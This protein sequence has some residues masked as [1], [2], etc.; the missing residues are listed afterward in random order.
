MVD[1]F[2][3]RHPEY[4]RDGVEQ[5]QQGATN[6]VIFA[7][8][9]DE[10]VV[11]K[12]FC[13]SERKERE[14]F[15]YRHWRGTGLV[16]ELIWDE[17]P[18]MIVM[19]HVPGVPLTAS[20][21]VDGEA[22]WG[23]TCRASGSAT[24]ALTR[25]PLSTAD[26]TDFESRF[27]DGLG[28]LEAYLGRIAELA[29]GV[30][31]RDPDFRGEFWRDSLEF[32]QAQLPA[33]FSQARCLYHQDVGNHHVRHGRFMG[34]YDLEMCRVGCAAMQ[35]GSSLGLLGVAGEAWEPFCT[36]WES[37]TG[38]PLLL[39]DLEAAVAAHHLLCWREITRYLSYDGTP[40]T[41]FAWAAPADPQRYQDSIETA[42]SMVSAR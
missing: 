39:G 32:M 16:P 19:Q 36:G 38:G 34:F 35:L 30:H 27:Y 6:R 20:R 25:V 9:G 12:V 28:P 7:R 2:V 4:T 11:F 33:I 5:P 21:E 15:A 8:C 24:G 13:E 10:T 17:H 41:G 22:M 37:A 40:G 29:Q 18:R 23:E 14:S 31:S 1:E 26:R 3:A 42:E